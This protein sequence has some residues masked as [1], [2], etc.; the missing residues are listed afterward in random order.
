MWHCK[1]QQ[2][3]AT[4]T[5]EAEFV[6]A[7]T[8]SKDTQYLRRVL[9]GL[10]M[11]QPGPTPVYEDNKACRMMSE[12][13]VSKSRT[14]HIDVAQHNVLDLVRTNIVRLINC[15]T[16]NMT[17]DVMTKALP[18]PS[19]RQHRDTV[20]GYTLPTAPSVPRRLPSWQH[21]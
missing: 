5:S 11:H 8:A 14:R 1:Q 6:S 17:A 2:G 20:L 19:F 9:A 12:N 21:V 10:G 18:A 13:P 4:S 15:P 16:A 3:V 7:S